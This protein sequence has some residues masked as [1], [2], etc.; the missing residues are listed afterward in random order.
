MKSLNADMKSMDVICR[1]DAL[2]DFEQGYNIIKAELQKIYLIV[3]K[4]KR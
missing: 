1:Q 4:M 3:F 2:E